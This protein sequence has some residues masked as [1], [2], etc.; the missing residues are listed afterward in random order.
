VVNRLHVGTSGWL[1][2]HWRG[3]FYPFDLTRPDYLGYY[4]RCFRTVEINSSFYRLPSAATVRAWREAVP[5]E[6]VFSTKASSYITHRKKLLEPERSLPI[7]VARMMYLEDQL[8][9]ILF[10]LPPRWRCDPGRL[11]A[12][13]ACLPSGLRFVFEFRDPSWFNEQTYESLLRYG[14][15]VCI[16]DLDGHVSPAEIETADFV[17]LRLHGPDGPYRGCY[18]LA[19]L[20]QWAEQISRWLR[21]GRDVYCYFDNDQAAYAAR[22]AAE[23][24]TLLK[25]PGGRSQP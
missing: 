4:A 2:P 5:A 3:V 24:C 8:G 21:A 10:Q 12:F 14:S 19:T 9:P 25:V 13:M 20:A 11:Q 18:G 7:F 22:N 6:F 23:L 17:Y 1:Y 16:H 15:A